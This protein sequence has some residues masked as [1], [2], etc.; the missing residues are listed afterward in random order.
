MR[1]TLRRI[2]AVS[3]GF[4]Q[5]AVLVVMACALS[6]TS[7]QASA[8]PVFKTLYSFQDGGGPQAT[9]VR[10][11]AGNLY[12]TAFG[13]NSV[14][15][16]TKDGTEKVLY[17]FCGFCTDG[18]LPAANLIIDQQGNLYGTTTFSSGAGGGTVFKLE[19]RH[20]TW[21][22]VL[23]HAFC[24]RPLCEDGAIPVRGLT[25]QG[26]SSGAPYDGVSPLYGATYEGG[27]NNEG[28]VYQLT[29]SPG[30]K[31]PKQKTIYSFCSMTNC[32][33]G[34]LPLGDLLVDDVGNLYGTT[35]TGGDF[36][37]RG[38]VVFELSPKG[39]QFRQ[40]V[41]YTFCQLANCADGQYPSASFAM[42]E[43]GRLFGT[44]QA[45]GD[46]GHGA[47]FELQP[48]GRSYRESVLYSF[49][50]AGGSCV[51]GDV[52]EG[53]ITNASGDLFGTTLRGGAN[54]NGVVFRVHGAAQTVLHTFC[55]AGDC[56]D[57]ASPVG[58]LMSDGLGNLLGTTQTGGSSG[59]GT[60]YELTP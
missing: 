13:G 60:L 1:I 59:Q 37:N 25:Y 21:K 10:D 20:G 4:L 47:V 23:L 31:K 36:S 52:P 50:P 17:T 5:T 43:K 56:S 54:G 7:E 58:G 24:S 27:A 3:A 28:V 14:Y 30:D 16:F 51:D 35:S 22:F 55:A 18:S 57:G 15:E 26:M 33:D 9:V 2:G 34:A 40:R 45:G 29:F 48:H 53:V 8:T 49:C 39:K 46:N 32:S 38:G 41:L 11:S 12:G 19:P 42:D 6:L 44:T